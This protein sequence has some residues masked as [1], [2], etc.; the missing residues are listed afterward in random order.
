M[1][2]IPAIQAF[3]VSISYRFRV[4][5][6]VQLMN[7]AGDLIQNG[8][9]VHPFAGNLPQRNGIGSIASENFLIDIQSYSGHHPF[10]SASLKRVLY[11]YASD[12][13]IAVIDVIRP[14]YCK[15]IGISIQYLFNS[16]TYK[17]RYNKLFIYFDVH[18]I[19]YK[20]KQEVFSCFCFPRI[21]HLSF[22]GR[23]KIGTDQKFLRQVSFPHHLYQKRVGRMC[24]FYVHNERLNDVVYV[25]LFLLLFRYLKQYIFY[26]FCY[27][28]RSSVGIVDQKSKNKRFVGAFNITYIAF[29]PGNSSAFGMYLSLQACFVEK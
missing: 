5:F 7:F 23:L 27:F 14:F 13:F 11:Q 2:P 15:T 10:Q 16:N 20:T 19:K 3:E 24:L 12:L 29:Y 21:P 25:L 18:R 8:L 22:S 1:Q 6:V 9:A 4:H 26:F 28:A 17:L